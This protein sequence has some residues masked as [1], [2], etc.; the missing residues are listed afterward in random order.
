MNIP[1]I[2]GITL[3]TNVP[4]ITAV[5]DFDGDGKQDVALVGNYTNSTP[6]LYLGG[7]TTRYSEAVWVYYG[8]GDTTFSPAVSAGVFYDSPPLS[9][10]AAAFH[11][12]GPTELVALSNSGVGAFADPRASLLALLTSRSRGPSGHHGISSVERPSIPFNSPTSITMANSICSPPMARGGSR[13]R[14]GQILLQS[15]STGPT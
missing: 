13:P 2:D 7:N 14:K 15:S 1:S 8:N 10:T 12:G 4:S 6:S 11:S 3:S 9:I 5:G